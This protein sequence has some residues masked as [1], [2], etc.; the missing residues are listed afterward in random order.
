MTLSDMIPCA[1]TVVTQSSQH[2]ALSP[3]AAIAKMADPLQLIR[4]LL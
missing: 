1:L 2:A 4:Q 3:S